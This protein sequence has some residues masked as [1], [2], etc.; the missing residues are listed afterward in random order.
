MLLSSSSAQKKKS[1]DMSVTAMIH[2]LIHE[3]VTNG[4]LFGYE[5][6]GCHLLGSK[7]VQTC[8]NRLTCIGTVARDVCKCA[9]VKRST[10]IFTP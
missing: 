5:M 9:S 1:N 7:A 10:R 6:T 3:T 2:V 8:H 4:T